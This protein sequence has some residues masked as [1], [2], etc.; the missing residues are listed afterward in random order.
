M[1]LPSLS[2]MKRSLRKVRTQ[3]ATVM[4]VPVSVSLSSADLIDRMSMGLGLRPPNPGLDPGEGG[5][6]CGRAL[7]HRVRA[8][9]RCLNYR[10]MLTLR[11]AVTA[12]SCVSRASMASF[13]CLA[14][15]SW[16]FNSC[17]AFTSG[18]TKAS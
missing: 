14:A 18:I 9:G 16:M 7:K 6:R 12:S 13:A 5:Q 2:A 4:V 15:S 10:S 17:T 11:V 1:V 3:P 8:D